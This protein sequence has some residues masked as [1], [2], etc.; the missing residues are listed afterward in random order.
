MYLISVYFDEQTD[1]TIRNYINKVAEETGNYFMRDNQ[2]PPHITVAAI[3]TRHEQQAIKCLNNVVS[4]IK[5]DMI[6]WVTIGS[7]VPHVI[8]IQ[9][10]LNE[11][12]HNMTTVLCDELSKISETIVS[13]YYKPFSWLPHCTI[14]KQLTKEQMSVAHEVMQNRFAP[15]K[16]RVV[17]IG[18]AK[19]NPHRDIKI[20]EFE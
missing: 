14:G 20:W 1:R 9:P 7:F 5:S 2:V 11:Y 13:P 3:E 4:Q 17:K 6:H 18:L 16:G 12:L 15:F 10:V 8:F 19:T